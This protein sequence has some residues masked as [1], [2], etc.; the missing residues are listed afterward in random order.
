MSWNTILA[1][2]NTQWLSSKWYLF[3]LFVHVGSL[4]MW[5]RFYNI[6]RA[7]HNFDP[8]LV[9]RFFA[10]WLENIG[11]I[12]YYKSFWDPCDNAYKINRVLF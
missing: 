9:L 12:S 8:V 1:I 6:F 11:T 10:R 3:T 2:F 5:T 7:F 4:V